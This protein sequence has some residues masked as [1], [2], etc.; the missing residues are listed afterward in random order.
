[1]QGL[2]RLARRSGVL[3][4]RADCCIWDARLFSTVE[5]HQADVETI[6]EKF[7]E[8]RDELEYAKEEVGTVYYNEAAQEARAV[9]EATLSMFS[10]LL[11]KLQEDE[12]QKLQR[13]MG[14]KMEQLK[15]SVIRAVK[16]AHPTGTNPPSGLPVPLRNLT[17]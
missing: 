17:P 2:V 5:Q 12:K 11:D 13:S 15:V 8:A 10:G 9:V 7:T 6:N 3:G 14:M 16:D 1:M 4:K